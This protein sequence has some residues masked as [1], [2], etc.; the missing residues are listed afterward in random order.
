[1]CSL[2]VGFDLCL[3][4]WMK[5]GWVKVILGEAVCEVET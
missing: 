4:G 3:L 1:M 5:V 2:A